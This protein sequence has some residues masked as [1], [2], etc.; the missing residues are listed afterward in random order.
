MFNLTPTNADLN[1]SLASLA[2]TTQKGIEKA[3][4]SSGA[5]PVMALTVHMP[6]PKFQATV[7]PPVESV[8]ELIPSAGTNS[9]REFESLISST[10]V[11]AGRLAVCTDGTE[12]VMAFFLPL[13]T[14]LRGKRALCGLR[15]T[16][17]L[18]ASMSST[19]FASVGLITTSPRNFIDIIPSPDLSCTRNSTGSLP[20]SIRSITAPTEKIS[21]SADGGRDKELGGRNPSASAFVRSVSSGTKPDSQIALPPCLFASAEIKMLSGEMAVW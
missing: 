7:K 6:I 10:L 15:K 5:P 4:K 14:C 20:E 19:T 3:V 18:N 11:F 1:V 12:A 16:G 17:L 9:W 21:T 8:D 13:A 2:P